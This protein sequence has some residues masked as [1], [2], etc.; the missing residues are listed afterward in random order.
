MSQATI[1]A[2][3]GAGYIFSV[4][5]CTCYANCDGSTAAPIL[6]VSDFICFMNLYAAGDP[7]ANCDGSTVA[8]TLN[9]A[10]FVCF[11]NAYAAGC[12]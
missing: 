4:G 9:V 5:A 7:Q 3:A 12:P 6:N 8:P 10:D 1:A 11:L 2:N